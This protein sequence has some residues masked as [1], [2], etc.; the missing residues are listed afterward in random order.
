M[1]YT[2]FSEVL[3]SGEPYSHRSTLGLTSEN[4]QGYCHNL[5]T[6][7][8]LNSF[9]SKNVFSKKAIKSFIEEIM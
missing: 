7:P 4:I 5:S 9:F 3:V 6:E 8:E 2:N 1:L